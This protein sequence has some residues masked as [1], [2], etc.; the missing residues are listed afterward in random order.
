[1]RVIDVELGSAAS[2]VGLQVNDILLSLNGQTIQNVETV[3]AIA[4]EYSG[5]AIT[6]MVVTEGVEKEVSI[7]PQNG[8]LGVTLCDLANCPDPVAAPPPAVPGGEQT[9]DEIQTNIQELNQLYIVEPVDV[10]AQLEYSP[11]S[12]GPTICRVL[13]PGDP[14]EVENQPSVLYTT[15]EAIAIGESLGICFAG[16][17]TGATSITIVS[18]TG[19]TVYQDSIAPSS[20]IEIRGFSALPGDV[21]GTYTIIAQT[22]DGERM[23]TFEII[24]TLPDPVM[25]L[26]ILSRSEKTL[27]QAEYIYL[28]GFAPSER[29]RLFFYEVCSPQG[30][31]F[32]AATE[33]TVNEQGTIFATLPTGLQQA[34]NVEAPHYVIARATISE[35]TE[36][37]GLFDTKVGGPSV[38]IAGFDATGGTVSRDCPTESSDNVPEGSK[39]LPSSPNTGMRI[40]NVEP[41]SPAAIAGFQVDYILVSLNGQSIS[42]VETAIS[43]A[44]E[45]SGTPLT[46]V[47]W[48]GTQE[49]ILD[50]TP[51]SPV[52]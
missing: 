6:A 2:Q 49:I 25:S 33:V 22:P 28:S 52:R 37:L 18:P 26:S 44:Q 27:T 16:F 12:G 39:T 1:M 8:L 21:M 19:E 32:T 51:S 14:Y 50:I 9:S 30:S 7:T 20:D 5:V 10:P 35:N 29:V 38:S 40:V 43:M 45:H 15:S 23:G 13:Y 34:L 48:D 41:G 24:D 31:I 17:T 46:A 47:L 42:T 3:R 11:P 4:E 36:Y